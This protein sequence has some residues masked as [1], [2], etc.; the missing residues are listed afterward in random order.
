MIAHIMREAATIIRC[1][2]KGFIVMKNVMFAPRFIQTRFMCNFLQEKHQLKLL[3]K[4]QAQF[5]GSAAPR[6][7]ERRRK[8]RAL[9]CRRVN[10]QSAF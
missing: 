10:M 6:V 3:T 7:Q 8:L 2:Q 4:R 1:E 9:S 5:S